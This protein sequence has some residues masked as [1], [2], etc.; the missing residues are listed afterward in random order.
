MMRSGATQGGLSPPVGLFYSSDSF[1]TLT[2]LVCAPSLSVLLLEHLEVAVSNPISMIGRGCD[3][4]IF[5]AD[6]TIDG[7]KKAA[8]MLNMSL[9]VAVTSTALW[10]YKAQRENLV[11]VAQMSNEDQI[12]FGDFLKHYG[13]TEEQKK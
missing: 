1:S 8:T 9:D 6:T 4:G 12:L 5:L 11:E 10:A 7:T 3:L 2:V 13:V